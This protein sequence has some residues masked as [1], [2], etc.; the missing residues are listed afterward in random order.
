[1]L[2]VVTQT[3]PT[4][5]DELRNCGDAGR[6]AFVDQARHDLRETTALIGAVS[7]VTVEAAE[8]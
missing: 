3:L 8:R 6:S 2:N 4:G 5:L 1:M 7:S